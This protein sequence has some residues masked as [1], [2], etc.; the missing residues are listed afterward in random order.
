MIWHLDYVASAITL[1]G[2]YV[3]GKC[4]W[5]GWLFGFVNCFLLSYINW[6]YGLWGFFPLNAVLLFLFAKNA[7]DWYRQ[8]PLSS[9][10]K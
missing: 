6:R 8:P 9:T 3:V 5:W 2:M 1:V 10:S 4:R 7:I